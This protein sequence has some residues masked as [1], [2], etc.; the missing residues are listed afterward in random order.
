MT[1][2][3]KV[4]EYNGT[5]RLIN[6]D[7]ITELYP[8]GT[9]TVITYVGGKYDSYRVRFEDIVKALEDITKEA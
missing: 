6:V 5:V 1:K 4:R 9:R 3:I 2:F 7:N 8:N